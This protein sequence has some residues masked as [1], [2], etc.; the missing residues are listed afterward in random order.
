M[1]KSTKLR[2]SS[3]DP[4]KV[5]DTVI[6]PNRGQTEQDLDIRDALASLIGKGNTLTPDD[7]KA[8]Y[9]ALTTTLGQDK[10]MK[11]MNH[12]YLFN[13]RPDVLRLPL[14]EKLKTFYTIGSN[15]PD[16]K[17]V[18]DKSKALGY[19]VVPGFRESS[20]AINQALV[21]RIENAEATDANSAVKNRIML[22]ISR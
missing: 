4:I 2:L 5:G 1:A 13:Q 17:Q 10:A 21:G 9:G 19:G 22:R 12:A 18:I 3:N 15:D 8:I 11:I 7:K 14:E 16:V 6:T 20:S